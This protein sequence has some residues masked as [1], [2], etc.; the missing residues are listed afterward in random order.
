[1]AD[2]DA[3]PTGGAEAD[4]PPS[5]EVDLDETVELDDGLDL[6]NW[7]HKDREAGGSGAGSLWATASAQL[8]HPSVGLVIGA[9]YHLVALAVYAS[10]LSACAIPSRSACRII[11]YVY[12]TRTTK[13][14]H[15]ADAARLMNYPAVVGVVTWLISLCWM[16]FRLILTRVRAEPK[17]IEYGPPC[18]ALRC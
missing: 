2:N 7:G 11:Y 18:A 3:A 10:P 8:R 9:A 14:G 6:D 13:L 1:M 17:E 12:V 5:M 4:P 15:C 16:M